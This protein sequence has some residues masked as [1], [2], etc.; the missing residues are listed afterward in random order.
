MMEV[1]GCRT[2]LLL[3]GRCSNNWVDAP[4]LHLCRT[5]L[6][7]GT[8]DDHAHVTNNRIRAAMDG[9]G[10]VD[11]IGARIYGADNLLELSAAQ[12]SPGHDLVFEKPSH[13]NLVIAGRLPNGVTN[14]ADHP[15]DRIITARAKGFSITTPPLPKPRQAV[16]N[17]HNTS[18]EIMITQPGT[19]SAWTLADTEGNVQTF[20][21]PLHPGH[22]IRL[23]PGESILLEYTDTPEWRWRSVPW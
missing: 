12:T 18:I 9:Q 11:A 7:L 2:A 8:P 23:A 15:T 1:V 6:Q 10:I 14:H 16:T 20:D 22:T 21:S 19:V 13:D 17:R 4:F 3:T 5:H